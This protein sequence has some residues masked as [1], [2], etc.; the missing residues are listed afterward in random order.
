VAESH[1]RYKA[2]QGPAPGKPTGTPKMPSEIV[3]HSRYYRAILLDAHRQVREKLE[4]LFVP[5]FSLSFASL[6]I[7]MAHQAKYSIINSYLLAIST[8]PKI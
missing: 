6:P 3:H 7:V 4:Q 1:L 8:Q 5:F 2:A